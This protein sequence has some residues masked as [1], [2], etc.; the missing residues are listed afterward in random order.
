[1]DNRE[2]AQ[3]LIRLARKNPGEGD[4]LL[5]WAEELLSARAQLADTG[6]EAQATG[7]QVTFPVSIFRV[8]KHRRHDAL[9]LEGWRVEMNGSSYSS[10]SA[11]AIAVSGNSEN[12]WIVWKYTDPRT[13]QV[14][15]ID[16]LRRAS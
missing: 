13:G 11:A 8:Y 9:L 7:G 2:K 6:R 5:M 15:L 4:A 3:L 14:A 16:N 10:P 12:G 1:M